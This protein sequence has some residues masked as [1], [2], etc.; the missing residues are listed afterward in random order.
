MR[1]DTIRS[2]ATTKR[3]NIRA[4]VYSVHKT[5]TKYE[6]VRSIFR[7]EAG[8]DNYNSFKGLII[9]YKYTNKF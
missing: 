8:R 5:V 7:A 4:E 9:P 1:G 3:W 2:K 6:N